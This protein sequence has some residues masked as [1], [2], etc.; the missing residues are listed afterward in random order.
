MNK[1]TI[2]IFFLKKKKT[3]TYAP[4]FLSASNN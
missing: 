4:L 2:L 1:F 3:R